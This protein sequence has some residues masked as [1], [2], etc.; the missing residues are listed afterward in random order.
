[1]EVRK[2]KGI[3]GQGDHRLSITIYNISIQLK[4]SSSTEYSKCEVTFVN[5]VNAKQ[6]HK[7]TKS[8]EIPTLSA[9]TW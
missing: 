2:L 9:N 8:A 5:T 4:N 6:S 3:N 7:H 1:M